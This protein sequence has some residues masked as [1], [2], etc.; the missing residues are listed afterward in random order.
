M[1]YEGYQR[2]RIAVEGRIVTATID[3]PPI[4]LITRELY[5]ELAR[6]A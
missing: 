5:G 6:L 3:N 1:A 4:N 2:L